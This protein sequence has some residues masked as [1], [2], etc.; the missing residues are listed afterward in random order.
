[1]GEFLNAFLLYL[2]IAYGAGVLSGL[3][4]WGL[5]AWLS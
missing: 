2:A 3:G 4:I 5:W 1:M